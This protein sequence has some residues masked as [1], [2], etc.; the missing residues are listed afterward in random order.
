MKYKFGK[1]S[2]IIWLWSFVWQHWLQDFNVITVKGWRTAIVEDKRWK[3]NRQTISPCF[4]IF[5]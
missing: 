5:K 2:F 4:W 1:N 3:G